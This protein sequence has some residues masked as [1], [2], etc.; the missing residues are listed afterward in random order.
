MHIIFKLGFVPVCIAIYLFVS[1]FSSSSKPEASHVINIKT[2]RDLKDFFRYTKDRI[3]FISSH[4]GGPGRGFPENC[5]ATL[6]NTLKYT[7]SIMEIDPHYTKDS[8]IV[9]MHDATLDRTS[10]GRG[11]VSDYTLAEI[12]KLKLKDTEGNLTSETIPTL[13]EVLEWAKGKTVLIIDMKDVPVDVRVQKIKEHNAQ[14][15][16]MIM[17]YSLADAK[18]CYELD[19]DIMMEVFIADTK[20]AE[21]FDSTGVPWQNIVA[22][23]THVEPK[24]KAVFDYVHKKGAMCIRGS[25]RNIDKDYTEGKITDEKLLNGKYRELI[26]EGADII[27]A[28]LGIRAGQAIK[29]LQQSK[30]SK[31]KYFSVSK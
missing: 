26:T 25:S 29:A 23:V 3:P 28:D 10:N 9:L 31:R 11:K 30:S 19:K 22:F 5:I 21:A 1:S 7:W 27:E 20:A 17:A 14:A 13:D 4:R 16:A 24:D 15:N 12:R 2:P 8:A 18:R 6:E